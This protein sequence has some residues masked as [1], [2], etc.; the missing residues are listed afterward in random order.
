M[1]PN[2]RSVIDVS[3]PK[4]VFLPKT[5][6]L[7]QRSGT[8]NFLY[9]AIVLVKHAFIAVEGTTSSLQVGHRTR[10]RERCGGFGV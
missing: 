2:Q 8:E 7:N 1:V 5:V 4:I 6:S 10:K 3:A 9:K